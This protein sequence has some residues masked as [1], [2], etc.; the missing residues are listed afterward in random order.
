MTLLSHYQI[1]VQGLHVVIVGRS[2]IVGKPL[3]MMMINAG[4]TVTDCNSHTRDLSEHTR[5]A[6]IVVLAAGQP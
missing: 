6:D 4:A 1:S 3:T 2:N 5:R